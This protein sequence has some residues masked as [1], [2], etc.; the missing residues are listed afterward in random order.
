MQKK[1]TF[2]R[3]TFRFNGRSKV[4]IIGSSVRLGSDEQNFIELA[5]GTAPPE[6]LNWEY[7][8]ETQLERSER[9]RLCKL[10]KADVDCLLTWEAYLRG[11]RE[12]IVL[13]H[14]LVFLGVVYQVSPAHYFVLT[15]SCLEVWRQKGRRHLRLILMPWAAE[16]PLESCESLNTSS[17]TLM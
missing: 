13:A 17:T 9:D 11:I 16:N 4:Y 2:R 6:P 1:T 10:L 3:D 12:I 5:A 8:T 7:T 15:T 14:F